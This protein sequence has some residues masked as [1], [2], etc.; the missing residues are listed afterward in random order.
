MSLFIVIALF[1][2]L[3]VFVA[4]IMVGEKKMRQAQKLE[5]D[6]KF[7]EACYFYAVAIFNGLNTEEQRQCE[8]RIRALWKDRGPFDYADIDSEACR[9]SSLGHSETL[10]IIKELVSDK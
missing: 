7:R 3:I 10:K 5:A 9:I 8:S 6:A 2:V 4:K 1:I